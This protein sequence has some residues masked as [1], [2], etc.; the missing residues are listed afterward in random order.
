MDYVDYEGM[1][2]GVGNRA[3]NEGLQRS[4]LG[5]VTPAP[6]AQIGT[7]S[8]PKPNLLMEIAD[9]GFIGVLGILVISWI[10]HKWEKARRKR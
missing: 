4:F 10:L 3:L 1:L 5:D 2:R 8:P 7:P 9:I 6:Q